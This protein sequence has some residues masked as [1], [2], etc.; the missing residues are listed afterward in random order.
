MN[1]TTLADDAG[2]FFPF[3][4]PRPVSFW[5]KDTL[6]PLDIL[7]FDANGSFITSIAM[8]PCTSN[9]DSSCALYP[10]PAPVGSALEVPAGYV[11]QHQVGEGWKIVR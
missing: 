3:D 7:Y 8:Q 10:S 9:D 5:M 1:R 11:A 2:M 4:P 6:I